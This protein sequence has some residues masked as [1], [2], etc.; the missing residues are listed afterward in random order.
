MMLDMDIQSLALGQAM[1]AKVEK[2]RVMRLR[3]EDR[4][5]KERSEIHFYL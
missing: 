2:S 3:P 1:D 4:F 5:A